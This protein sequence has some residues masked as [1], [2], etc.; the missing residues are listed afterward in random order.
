LPNEVD[1]IVLK[2]LAKDPEERFD[3]AS[4]LGAALR[5]L[6]REHPWRPDAANEWWDA[7][8]SAP[9]RTSIRPGANE[10]T[11]DLASR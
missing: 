9:P 3:G 6:A 2:C 5:D 11:V 8:D 4:E 1:V 10:V 7:L